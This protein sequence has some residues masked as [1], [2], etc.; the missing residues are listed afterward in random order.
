MHESR[1]FTDSKRP[2]ERR[3]RRSFLSSSPD[4]LWITVVAAVVLMLGVGVLMAYL[5]LARH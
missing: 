3:S 5:P 2:I 4:W 1:P